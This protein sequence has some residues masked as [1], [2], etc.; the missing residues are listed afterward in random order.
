VRRTKWCRA[1]K[2]KIKVGKRKWDGGRR[3]GSEAECCMAERD[4]AVYIYYYYYI[5][6]NI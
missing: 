3:K 1:A 6:Y 5:I 4:F 2:K